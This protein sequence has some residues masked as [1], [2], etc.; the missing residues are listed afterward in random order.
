M[1]TLN[2]I[3][4]AIAALCVTALVSTTFAQEKTWDGEG[5]DSNLTTADNWD[6][7]TA[8]TN[9][10]T[11]IDDEWEFAGSTRT[12]PTAAVAWTGISSINF[13]ADAAFT[14]SGASL[15]FDGAAPHAI[16]SDDALLHT[17]NN[18][19]D[20]GA[21]TMSLSAVAGGTL[22]FN[23]IISGAGG[24]L[25]VSGAG[26]IQLNA[27]NTFDAGVTVGGTAIVEVNN[28]NGLGAGDVTL[29]G[30]TL[31]L[32]ATA[33]N[34]YGNN[35]DVNADSTLTASINSILGA[36]ATL[37]GAADLTKNGAGR[38]T[39]EADGSA[40]TGTLD[41]DAGILRIN[42]SVG[43]DVNNNA[44]ATLQGDGTIGGSL[45]NNADSDTNPGAV[46]N[47]IGTLTIEG[48]FTHNTDATLTIELS[49]D[50]PVTHGNFPN[51]GAGDDND[52][53]D[54]TTGGTTAT[55][56]NDSIVRM[57]TL[58]KGYIA[59][60]DSF[61][62]IDAPT[63]T[64]N[65]ADVTSA[66]NFMSFTGSVVGGD[67]YRVTANRISYT[68]AANSDNRHEVA[69]GLDFLAASTPQTTNHD[70][71]TLLA[72]L[73][74]LGPGAG[75]T[76]ALDYLSPERYDI[77]QRIN[78]R[79]TQR[80]MDTQADYITRRRMGFPMYMMS[81][82]PA[83]ENGES[84]LPVGPMF[85][86]MADDPQVMG[87]AI[88]TMEDG[89]G[90]DR[91]LGPGWT[92]EPHDRGFNVYAF[93]L[94]MD[95]EETNSDDRT[96]YDADTLGFQ[97]GVDWMV[98]DLLI[99]FSA[100]YTNTDVDYRGLGGDADIDSYRFGP[101]VSF[102][103]AD[104]WNVTFALSYAY[105]HQESN[106]PIVVGT[107]TRNARGDWDGHEIS[108]YGGT[109]YDL[110]PDEQWVIAPAASFQYVFF[111]QK[112]FTESG[113]SAANL[114]LDDQQTHSVDLKLGARMAYIWHIDQNWTIVPEASVAWRHELLDDA[115][116]T[117][118]A[119]FVH[120]NQGF[121]IDRGSSD[122]DAL[123][124]SAGASVLMSDTMSIFARYTGVTAD[125]SDSTVISG[126]LTLQF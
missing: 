59:D 51:D 112:D 22:V 29:D 71:E 20:I 24:D 23:G 63:V 73:D 4:C 104:R 79:V 68:T 105:H 96:G 122:R 121:E 113:A 72:E 56:E 40:Y 33:D 6:A 64:D 69:E 67:V 97:A 26:T 37:T 110:Y 93:G 107:L 116:D 106:R 86:S 21:A 65:G 119:R 66:I 89:N 34:I 92:M 98:D 41:N 27:G 95:T 32:S 101:Y 2:R 91:N 38:L 58:A 17:I 15:T 109:D 81:D 76:M 111:Y 82:A 9:P 77:V 42:G 102:S 87:Q 46:N 90:M 85:A 47:A 120:A 115:D 118:G 99:G 1:S 45:V 28:D 12:D 83:M 50:S 18:A 54:L 100:A 78:R 74:S 31:D 35:I 7:D 43:G 123:E 11:A 126:G 61:D 49:P 114:T 48:D 125:D 8:P 52:H 44:N 124:Y 3:Q 62:I 108:V 39:I 88:D 57:E 16:T 75:F 103:P 30:G 25:D 5:A 10:P 13:D 70:A 14:L 117:I 60:G 94:G 80:M 19:I 36:A 53:V 84:A 55:L